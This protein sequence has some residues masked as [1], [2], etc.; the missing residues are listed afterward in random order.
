MKIKSLTATAL[1]I[2]FTACTPIE[3]KPIVYPD[4]HYNE[5]RYQTDLSECQ[6]WAE[7]AVSEDPTVAEGAVGGSIGGALL[8]AASGA[9]IGAILG[10]ASIGAQVGAAS[11]G[12]EGAVGGATSNYGTREERKKAAVYTCLEARGYRVAR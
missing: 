4:S 10:D 7:R 11:G 5:A 8:G 12:M 9:A 2:T 1:L 3:R 6:G